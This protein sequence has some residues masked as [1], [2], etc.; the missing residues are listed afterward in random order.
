[1]NILDKNILVLT[2]AG[3]SKESGIST[4]REKNG[5]WENYKIEDVCTVE[6]F[7]R[8]PDLVN[9]FYNQ[10]RRDI[11]EKNIKPNEAHFALAKLEQKC[12]KKFLLVTQNVDKLHEEAGSKQIRHMHGSL[13]EAYCMYCKNST[14][15]DFDLSTKYK[16]KNCH[17]SGMVRVDVVWFGEQPKFLDCI[18]KFIEQVEV[19]ISIGTSNNVYPAAGFIDLITQLLKDVKLYEFNLETT[20]KSC[21]FTEVYKGP[22]TITLPKFVESIIQ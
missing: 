12:R 13:Y 7:Q 16:C 21:L 20:H 8:N 3:I 14:N 18:Y 17:N 15:L 2:G 5:L 11:T 9:S 4:F 19:F 6:A 22:A 1:M 10:R